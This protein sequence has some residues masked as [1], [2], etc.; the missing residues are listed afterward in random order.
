MADTAR[1][2]HQ[3]AEYNRRAD[4]LESSDCKD[5]EEITLRNP[6]NPS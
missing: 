5:E 2:L 6:N 3:M 4:M 1:T